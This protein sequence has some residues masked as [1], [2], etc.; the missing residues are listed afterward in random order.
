MPIFAP[1]SAREGHALVAAISGAPGA[2]QKAVGAEA[3]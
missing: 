3:T 2:V 1:P